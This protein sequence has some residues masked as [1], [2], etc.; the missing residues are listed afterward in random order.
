MTAVEE[1]VAQAKKRPAE[2]PFGSFGLRKS[3]HLA[4]EYFNV[5]SGICMVHV[6]FTPTP[7]YPLPIAH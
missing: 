1:F 4:C 7:N 6:R 2:L 5:H 3:R